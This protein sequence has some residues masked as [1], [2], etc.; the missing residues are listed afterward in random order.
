[1]ALPVQSSLFYAPVQTDTEMLFFS[2]WYS[3][4]FSLSDVTIKRVQS[5]PL[6]LKQL[7]FAACIARRHVMFQRVKNLHSVSGVTTSNAGKEQINFCSVLGTKLCTDIKISRDD[8]LFHRSL[9]S[10]ISMA[11]TVIKMPAGSSPC[12]AYVQ[13]FALSVSTGNVLFFTLRSEG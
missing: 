6:R 12:S 11:N 3:F 9:C 10:R 5:L 2:S 8:P 13:L 4:K 1:M 7:E